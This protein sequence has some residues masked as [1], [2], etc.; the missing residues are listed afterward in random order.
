MILRKLVEIESMNQSYLNGPLHEV[1]KRFRPTREFINTIKKGEHYPS[2]SEGINFLRDIYNLCRS[3]SIHLWSIPDGP[4]F[5]VK[6]W[7]LILDR[8]F[9]R[10]YSFNQNP[11]CRSQNHS[12][13]LSKKQNIGWFIALPSYLRLPS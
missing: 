10:L 4:V 8:L 3:I 2:L 1:V 7:M 6:V 11:I 12:S 9:G 13:I 5:I